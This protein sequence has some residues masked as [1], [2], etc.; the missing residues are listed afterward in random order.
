[1]CRHTNLVSTRFSPAPDV[2]A[3]LEETAFIYN[4]MLKPLSVIEKPEGAYRWLSGRRR[5]QGSWVCLCG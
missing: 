3:S 2:K 1:M 4:E 5:E